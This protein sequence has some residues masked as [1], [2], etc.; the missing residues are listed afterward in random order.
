VKIGINQIRTTPA[1][2]EGQPPIGASNSERRSDESTRLSQIAAQEKLDQVQPVLFSSRALHARRVRP[3]IKAKASDTLKISDLPLSQ[4]GNIQ[5]MKA[6]DFG[7]L[8]GF[9]FDPKK[10]RKP[11]L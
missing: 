11:V 9:E 2:I 3:V 5:F 4:G 7:R 1:T 6:S 10:Q 8:N